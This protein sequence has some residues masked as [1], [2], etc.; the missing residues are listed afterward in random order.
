MIIKL[1]NN[2]EPDKVNEILSILFNLYLFFIPPIIVV[3]VLIF[4]LY[5]TT[6]HNPT[7]HILVVPYKTIKNETCIHQLFIAC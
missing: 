6:S 5:E 3:Y 2:G 4:I 1:S 7:Y